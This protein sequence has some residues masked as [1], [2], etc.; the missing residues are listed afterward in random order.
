M[1]FKTTYFFV[2]DHTDEFTHTNK[3][4]KNRLSSLSGSYL[5]RWSITATT[6]TV[7]FRSNRNMSGLV[8]FWSG[9]GVYPSLFYLLMNH[10]DQSAVLNQS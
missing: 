7:N 4:K 3:T 8:W 1:K 5:E 10:Y 2:V 9:L 6:T